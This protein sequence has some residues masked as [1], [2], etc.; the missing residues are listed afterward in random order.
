[1]LLIDGYNLLHAVVGGRPGAGDRDRLVALIESYCRRGSYRARIVFD[2]TASLRRRERRGEVEI[3]SVAQGRTA[4]EE[5]L[6][7]LAATADRTAYTVVSNDRRIADA[8]RKRKFKVLSCEEFARALE[9]LPPADPGAKP[10][11]PDDAEVE[12]W[13]EEFGLPG[14]GDPPAPT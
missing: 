4:D 12:G 8:A 10:A 6:A 9:S 2:A 7:E 11:G 14:E 5:I 1:M 3:R 13:M